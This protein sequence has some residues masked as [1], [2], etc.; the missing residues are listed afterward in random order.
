[1]PGVR[2]LAVPL[3]PRISDRRELA[4]SLAEISDARPGTTAK[5]WQTHRSSRSSSGATAAATSKCVTTGDAE[6][7]SAAAIRALPGAAADRARLL[8]TPLPRPPAEHLRDRHRPCVTAE[9]ALRSRCDIQVQR[10]CSPTVCC[11]ASSLRRVG[12]GRPSR[13]REMACSPDASASVT[14]SW[15]GR[16]GCRR[17]CA[18]YQRHRCAAWS[19]SFATRIALCLAAARSAKRDRA[20]YRRGSGWPRRRARVSSVIPAPAGRQPSRSAAR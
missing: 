4:R 12:A 11:C 15:C 18:G 1:M 13:L 19:R 2:R 14:A 3:R 5:G 8:R 7:R 10:R 17:S 20:P 16:K 6:R 9:D